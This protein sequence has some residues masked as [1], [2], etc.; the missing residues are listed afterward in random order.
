MNHLSYKLSFKFSQFE[1]YK[2]REIFLIIK[3]FNLIY[4]QIAAYFPFSHSLPVFSL[5]LSSVH[6][7]S[8]SVKKR[9]RPLM[10]VNKGRHIKL[11][12]DYAPPLVSRPGKAIPPLA[13]GFQNPCKALWT[14]L[15]PLRGVLQDCHTYAEGQ[16]GPM[17]AP[18][19]SFQSLLASMS[20]S[21]VSVGYL[22]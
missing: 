16:A 19:P 14:G 10:G 20:R 1:M 13:T 2:S 6:S 15:F 8:Y 18:K 3:N 11:R 5:S 12:Q 4:I 21:V 17:K 7:S 22:V 9:S